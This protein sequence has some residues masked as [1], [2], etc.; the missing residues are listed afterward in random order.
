[1]HSCGDEEHDGAS[2]AGW[3]NFSK[4]SD[5]SGSASSTNSSSAGHIYLESV[6]KT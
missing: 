1:M 5:T 6:P 2:H 4:L 3:A